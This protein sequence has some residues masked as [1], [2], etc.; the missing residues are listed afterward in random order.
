[1]NGVIK[2]DWNNKKKCGMLDVQQKESYYWFCMTS[3][4]FEPCIIEYFR[5]QY[6]TPLPKNISI[7][8]CLKE[9]E[10]RLKR[11]F[12]CFKRDWGPF[13]TRL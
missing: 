1:M 4:L 2:D 11:D 7:L 5:I 12:F 6:L 8:L 3:I 10:L 9:I 13:K